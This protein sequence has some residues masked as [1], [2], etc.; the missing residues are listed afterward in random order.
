MEAFSKFPRHNKRSAPTEFG[1]A[2]GR[3]APLSEARFERYRD[4]LF[5]APPA[6]RFFGLRQDNA[7]HAHRYASTPD[8]KPNS[9]APLLPRASTQ[10]ENNPSR[11]STALPRRSCRSDQIGRASCRERV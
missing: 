9:K 7:R 1:S 11:D 10:C 2:P 8:Q 4:K 5:F 6:P 3:S